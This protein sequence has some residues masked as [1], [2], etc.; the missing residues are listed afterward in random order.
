MAN[1]LSVPALGLGLG[2][3]SRNLKGYPD[4]STLAQRALEVSRYKV[5]NQA[6]VLQIENNL[7][8]KT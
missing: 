5:W 7:Y 2:E 4:R 1:G 3:Q 6:K 8:I